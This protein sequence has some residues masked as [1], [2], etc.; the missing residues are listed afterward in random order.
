MDFAA[1]A[2]LCAPSVASRTLQSIATVESATN[3]F[4]IGVVG[5]RLERQP[6]SMA[7]A[8]ATVRLLDGLGYDYSL[9]LLQINARN[10]GKLGL[11]AETA[12]DPCQNLRGASRIYNDCLKRAGDSDRAASDALSCYYSGNFKTG[13]RDGYVAKYQTSAPAGGSVD[14]DPIPIVAV[15]SV[16]GARRGARGQAPS[17][18]S[19]P[20]TSRF[21]SLDVPT[22]TAGAASSTTSETPKGPA[23]ALLF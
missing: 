2:E 10:L 8:M 12:F 16:H 23:T 17:A 14:H 1:M 4:A 11:T 20:S 5:G 21:V 19:A 13:Y 15:A 18:L 22:T 7:E 3:P 9:G 6:R